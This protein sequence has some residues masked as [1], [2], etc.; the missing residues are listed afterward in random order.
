MDE[1]Q[2]TATKRHQI[3]V[4]Q[5]LHWHTWAD[6]TAEDLNKPHSLFVMLQDHFF[7]SLH[8][9]CLATNADGAWKAS[10]RHTARRKLRRMPMTA[11]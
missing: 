3:C 5:Q 7:D 2:S 6:S 1:A 4:E 11:R 9:T 8:E 10:W